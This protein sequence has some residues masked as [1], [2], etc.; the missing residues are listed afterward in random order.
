MH[1]HVRRALELGATA[2]EIRHLVTLAVPTV[3]FPNAAAAFTW[4]EDVLKAPWVGTVGLPEVEFP[5]ISEEC[6]PVHDQ[7]RATRQRRRSDRDMD[8]QGLIESATMS[9][10]T[11]V[12]TVAKTRE[13]LAGRAHARRNFEH[14]Q[15]LSV[16]GV[17]P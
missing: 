6:S 4:I 11:R 12:P 7:G 14:H 2:S 17:Q 1:S 9:N 13:G 5:G 10:G 16:S 8:L 3:G 15:S